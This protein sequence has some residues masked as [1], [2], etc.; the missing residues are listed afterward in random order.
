MLDYKNYITLIC[1]PEGKNQPQGSFPGLAL[2]WG[3]K[4][5]VYQTAYQ[6]W[7]FILLAQVCRLQKSISILQLQAAVAYFPVYLW[8]LIEG[9]DF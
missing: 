1:R 4:T 5:K 6:W 8:K 7:Y 3:P 9:A 2:P